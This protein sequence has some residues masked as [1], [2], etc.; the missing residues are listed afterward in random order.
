METFTGFENKIEYAMS[1]HS[2]DS[3]AIPLILY[4]RSRE[5]REGREDSK[6]KKE[7]GR[8]ADLLHVLDINNHR[9]PCKRDTKCYR[10]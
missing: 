9:S 2:G 5:R 1:G 4:V 8:K 6:I 10:P 3:H 7:N